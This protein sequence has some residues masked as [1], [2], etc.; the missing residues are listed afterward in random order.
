[1]RIDR[2]EKMGSPPP[3]TYPS[4]I[5]AALPKNFISSMDRKYI[6]ISDRNCYC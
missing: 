1:M 3:G 2:K 6:L 5:I 4:D